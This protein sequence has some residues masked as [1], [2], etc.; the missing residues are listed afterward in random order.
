MGVTA[1]VLDGEGTNLE[2]SEEKITAEIRES[3]DGKGG[4]V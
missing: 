4:E 3:Q 2:E 1:V